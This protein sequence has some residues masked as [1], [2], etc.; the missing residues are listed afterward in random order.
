MTRKTAILILFSVAFVTVLTLM[1]VRP[2]DQLVQV[3]KLLL[4][5]MKGLAVEPASFAPILICRS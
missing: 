2:N 4:E 3:F 1:V 5:A